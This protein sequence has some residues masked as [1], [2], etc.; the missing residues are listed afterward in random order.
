[1]EIVKSSEFPLSRVALSN[2]GKIIEG[3][4]EYL[5]FEA[6]GPQN[7]G[8]QGVDASMCLVQGP[9]GY[10]YLLDVYV[11]RDG[12]FKRYVMKY[13]P[14]EFKETF[15]AFRDKIQEYLGNAKRYKIE[16]MYKGK[17]Q[18]PEY[19]YPEYRA[20]IELEAYKKIWSNCPGV[21]FSLIEV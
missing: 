7:N 18:G 8:F 13:P 3:A 1:M 6:I 20:Q 16:V 15:A 4:N 11:S 12:G 9:H 10:F 17:N 5:Y 2:P 21:V 14:H 19:A